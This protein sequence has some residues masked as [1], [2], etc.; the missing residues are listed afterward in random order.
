[1]EAFSKHIC[2]GPFLEHTVSSGEPREVFTKCY[3]P[4]L[5]T[6]VLKCLKSWPHTDISGYLLV[7]CHQFVHVNNNRVTKR[8]SL[9][10]QKKPGEGDKQVMILPGGNI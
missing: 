6:I 8:L 2:M 10:L 5:G 9:N 1:M 3:Q 4:R 7:L